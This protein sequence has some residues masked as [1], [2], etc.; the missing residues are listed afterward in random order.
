MAFAFEKLLVYQKSVAFAEAVCTA[1]ARFPRGYYFLAD[2]GAAILAHFAGQ[3]LDY[4]VTPLFADIPRTL[5]TTR[6]ESC[7]RRRDTTSR[8]RRSGGDQRRY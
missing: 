2:H 4:W 8:P 6:S 7:G 1:T 3:G 5:S